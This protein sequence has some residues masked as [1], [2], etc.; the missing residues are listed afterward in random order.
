MPPAAFKDYTITY[1]PGERIFSEGEKG[2]E[3][4]IVQRGRVEIF[5]SIDGERKPLAQMEKGD[6]FGELSV[7]L[8]APRSDSAE[9]LEKSELIVINSTLFDQ[10]IRSNIE[11]AVRI[12]R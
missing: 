2:A 1:Q 12:L 8:G 6:F 5:K 11:I 10:M 3:F 4:Y 9:A 7:L